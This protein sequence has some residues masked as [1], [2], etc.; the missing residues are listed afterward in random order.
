MGTEALLGRYRHSKLDLSIALF[1][2][3]EPIFKTIPIDRQSLQT[4]K[5]NP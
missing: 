1:Q 2:V 3:S 4:L 5:L